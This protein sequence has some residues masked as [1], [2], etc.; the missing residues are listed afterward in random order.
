MLFEKSDF[1]VR[2]EIDV[3]LKILLAFTEEVESFQN[4]YW[5]HWNL[6]FE[7]FLGGSELDSVDLVEAGIFE[8]VVPTR[9]GNRAQLYYVVEDDEKLES[10]E[11]DRFEKRVFC[12]SFGSNRV[13]INGFV[14]FLRLNSRWLLI[15]NIF[16]SIMS[17]NTDHL[18]EFHLYFFKFL[19]LFV[20]G[21]AGPTDSIRLIKDILVELFEL[22]VMKPFLPDAYS[23][24]LFLSGDDHLQV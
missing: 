23:F 18:R 3:I 5:D 15:Q 20:K 11:T 9:V 10:L 1:D 19:D 6:G 16:F 24:Q 13:D 2:V 8:V 4:V 17:W 21:K 14:F 12:F 22:T 7:S